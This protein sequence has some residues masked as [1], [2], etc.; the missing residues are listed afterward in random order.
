MKLGTK[1]ARKVSLA[2]LLSLANQESN[3]GDGQQVFAHRR[4]AET[5][6]LKRP[7]AD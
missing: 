2:V 1:L 4:P 3:K 6:F 7:G 5:Q